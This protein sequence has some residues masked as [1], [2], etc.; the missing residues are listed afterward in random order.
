MNSASESNLKNLSIQYYHDIDSTYNYFF[1]YKNQNCAKNLSETL[2]AIG[3]K[4]LTELAKRVTFQS[5]DSTYRI[6]L[7]QENIN[8][9]TGITQ[10]LNDK[11]KAAVA[12]VAPAVAPVAPVAPAVAPVAPVAAVA[13]VAPVA[14]V[15]PVDPEAVGA[16]PNLVK[17]FNTG[18]HNHLEADNWF[19][20]YF[21]FNE[22]EKNIKLPSIKKSLTYSSNIFEEDKS[23]I[24]FRDIEFK[25]DNKLFKVGR[26]SC[27][28]LNELKKEQNYSKSD[29]IELS[30]DYIEGNISILLNTVID[31]KNV[32]FQAASQFNL[33]EMIGPNK[34]P[35]H[36]IT[37]YHR[38][39]S[40]G[41][42]VALASPAGTFFRNYLIFKGES[43]TSERQINTLKEVLD[44]LK[45]KKVIEKPKENEYEYKNGY[46]F[47]NMPPANIDN[48][49]DTL[50]DCL[51]VGIQ[52]D[53]PLLIDNNRKMCQV[54]SSAL[55]IEYQKGLFDS[56]LLGNLTTLG[57]KEYEKWLLNIKPLAI[58]ILKSTFKCTLQVAVNKLSDTNSRSTVYLT[59]VGGGFFGNDIEWIQEAL[60]HALEEFKK[61]PLD[62]KVV[63]FK[64]A[65]SNFQI[66][67]MKIPGVTSKSGGYLIK[68][69]K[70]KNKYLKLKNKLL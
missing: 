22:T 36:G 59:P 25:I 58:A 23:K 48:L 56:T 14:A 66:E 10:V 70:Y 30:Y 44:K 18:V 19:H 31:A 33:L 8:L 9:L 29:K 38:D 51:R 49:Q 13:P 57:K 45:I 5:S 12:A 26:F 34:T 7:T 24:D 54:Y 65:E 61:Y 28:S 40:Q 11:I 16:P 47:I 27:L 3:I 67:N 63:Y 37:N 52:W 43:Q 62:V 35:E 42:R 39:N 32:V 21:G 15:A 17:K 50:D 64:N 60:K 2:F 53:T 68:Y 20:D 55:P 6:I 41:P 69:L 1:S 46:A 4:G